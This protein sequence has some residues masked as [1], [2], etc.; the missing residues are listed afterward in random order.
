MS[1]FF[2]LGFNRM[3]LPEA[4]GGLAFDPRPRDG[5]ESSRVGGQ[6]SRPR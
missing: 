3:A 2:E 6:G 5:R 1:Q 4:F